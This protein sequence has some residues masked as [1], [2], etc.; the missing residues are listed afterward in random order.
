[1]VTSIS[2]PSLE[3]SHPHPDHT[4]LRFTGC[5]TFDEYN[6]P[7][8]DKELSLLPDAAAGGH[9]VLDLGDIRYVTS[10]A[11]GTLIAF[12]RRV[13]SAGGRLALANVGTVILEILTVTRLDK[14][15]EIWPA[16]PPSRQ[17]QFSQD[18]R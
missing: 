7:A 15:L 13:Q 11:L 4:I 14:L 3:V 5:D 18:S 10:T 16:Q 9:V 12:N 8:V 1:M 2:A 6:I 17:R